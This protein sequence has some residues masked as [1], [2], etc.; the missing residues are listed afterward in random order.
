M[1]REA[2]R[3]APRKDTL[4]AGGVG[5]AGRGLR[6]CCSSFRRAQ[7]LFPRLLRMAGLFPDCSWAH[8][9]PH[10]S[11]PA[12]VRGTFCSNASQHPDTWFQVPVLRREWAVRSCFLRWPWE[13][14]GHRI[15]PHGHPSQRRWGGDHVPSV[16]L[17]KGAQSPQ[18]WP[19]S[20]C[21]WRYEAVT[22]KLEYDVGTMWPRTPSTGS[23]SSRTVHGQPLNLKVTL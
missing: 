10:A 21:W 14:S 4:W 23:C 20:R 17:R 13:G 8:T 22:Y 3:G 12:R 2:G 7:G 9:G 16:C 6:S 5:E 19:E 1:D 15:W 11:R 18:M